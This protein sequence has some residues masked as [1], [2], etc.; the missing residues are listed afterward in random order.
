MQLF[1]CFHPNDVDIHFRKSEDDIFIHIFQYL[2]VSFRMIGS[3][4]VFYMSVYQ[5]VEEN[6]RKLCQE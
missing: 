3:G 2:K 1:I 6:E 5:R 4:N